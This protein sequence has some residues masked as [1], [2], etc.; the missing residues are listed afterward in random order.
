MVRR[1]TDTIGNRTL[2]TWKLNPK[3]LRPA[4]VKRTSFSPWCTK[5][6]FSPA[7][8][9]RKCFVCRRGMFEHQ[10]RGQPVT[11][12]RRHR[13]YGDRQ[14]DRRTHLL[15]SSHQF[16]CTR[17]GTAIASSARCPCNFGPLTDLAISVFREMSI[18]T[19]LTQIL[20]ALQILHE[21][22]W[23]ASLRVQELHPPPNFP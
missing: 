13:D 20:W 3:L 15:F 14:R 17:Y 21:K 4:E 10:S 1:Y 23:R 9:R 7:A 2:H 5:A 6:T 8:W 16:F 22:N 12:A 19:V 11:S 18:N